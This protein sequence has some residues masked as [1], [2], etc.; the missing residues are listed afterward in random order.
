MVYLIGNEPSWAINHRSTSFP[1]A[2]AYNSCL[3]TSE[4]KNHAVHG[5]PKTKYTELNVLLKLNGREAGIRKTY[6]S[7][8]VIYLLR[9][10]C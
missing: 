6:C 2:A 4:L 3:F 7:M 8:D 9:S 5:Y 1:S 10:I